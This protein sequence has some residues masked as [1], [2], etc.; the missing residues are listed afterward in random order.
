[1]ADILKKITLTE[2]YDSG[3][4][5][6]AFYSTDCTNYT[7]SVD[8]DD[9]YLP[10]ISSVAYITVPEETT[11]IKLQ[12]VPGDCDN[13]VIVDFTPTTTSTST[14][15]TILPTTSTTTSTTSGPTTTTTSTTTILPSTTTT[16]S[17]TTILPS[18]TTTT[19]TSTTVAPCNCITVDVLNTQLTDGGLDLYYILN[20]C[21]GGSRDVNLAETIGSEVG[22]STYFGLCSRGTT[23]DLFKYGPSGDPFV[24]IEGMNI[25]PNVTVC[26]VD[27]DCLPVVPITTTT[28]TSTT[29]PLN[30]DSYYNNSSQVLTGI[31][32][33]DCSGNLI[34]DVTVGLGEDI[35]ASQEPFGGD[36]GFLVFNGPC[37]SPPSTTTTTTS[38][39]T[40]SPTTSTTTTSTTLANGTLWNLLCPSSATGGCPYTFTKLDGTLCSDTMPTDTDT[41]FCVKEGTTPTVTGGEWTEIGDPCSFN[42]CLENP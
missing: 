32:Y 3:P 29:Q 15:T 38:S 2:T 9:I 14:S 13:E 16:T 22:G 19:T 31:D 10:S 20:D 6:D 24:G 26:T 40:V 28:T 37:G 34:Q 4:Y 5:Y 33:Y 12:S 39:T 23:S 27:G 8:G 17:T 36:A 1:M 11:C 21:G 42:S 30:C 18:T 25:N 7:Q 35:C 41:I